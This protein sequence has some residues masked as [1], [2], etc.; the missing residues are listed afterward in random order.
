MKLIDL[1]EEKSILQKKFAD[2]NNEDIIGKEGAFDLQKSRDTFRSYQTAMK[3]FDEI[4]NILNA[5]SSRTC[6]KIDEREIS[7]ATAIDYIRIRE[8]FDNIN[9]GVGIGQKAFDIDSI[10]L[11][12]SINTRIANQIDLSSYRWGD[13]ESAN[14]KV[15]DPNGVLLKKKYYQD[16][17]SDYLVKLVIAVQK[18]YVLTDVD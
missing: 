9:C 1:I 15:L 14:V 2:Y 7:L 13:N 3:R 6:V 8:R 10:D 5:V 17:E 4:N 18:A 12:Y 11:Y 16:F